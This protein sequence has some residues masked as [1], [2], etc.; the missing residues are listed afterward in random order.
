MENFLRSFRAVRD[1][2]N[3][4]PSSNKGFPK[5]L[6]QTAKELVKTDQHQ[7]SVLPMYDIILTNL[8]GEKSIQEIKE[9]LFNISKYPLCLYL[10]Q[11][12]PEFHQIRVSYT[13][14][15]IPYYLE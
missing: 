15:R 13:E 8:E 10:D 12:R 2:P 14:R 3:L 9:G 7:Y 5:E 11:D 4:V 6:H 1:A